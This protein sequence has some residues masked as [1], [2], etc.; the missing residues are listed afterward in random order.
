M[1]GSNQTKRD[2]I[3]NYFPLPNEIYLL[4][5]STGEIAVYGYLLYRENRETYQCWPAYKTIGRA[6]NLSVTSV[7]KYVRKLVERGL[8]TTEPTKVKLEDGTVRNGTLCYTILPI[9]PV[10]DRFYEQQISMADM[11]R[12]RQRVAKILQEREQAQL[13][14][15]E[16][17]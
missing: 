11:E 5:L 7:R 1:K 14:P 13:T 8:I 10:I 3:K 9:Q 4:G 15:C 2:P 16:P 6:V 12:E 17:A